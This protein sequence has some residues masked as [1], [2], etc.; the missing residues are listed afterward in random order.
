MFLSSLA[1]LLLAAEAET[2]L[3]FAGGG[4]GNKIG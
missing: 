4:S 3:V 1:S 2:K